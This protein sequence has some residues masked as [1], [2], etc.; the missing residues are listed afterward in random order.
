MSEKVISSKNKQDIQSNDN[1]E[2]EEEKINGELDEDI[3]NKDDN[4]NKLDEEDT[5][6]NI[7][8]LKEKIKKPTELDKGE[9][10]DEA[11]TNLDETFLEKS[12]LEN[13]EVQTKKVEEE[14][15]FVTMNNLQA[16]SNNNTPGAKIEENNEF[17]NSDNSFGVNKKD[18]NE[19][20]KNSEKSFNIAMETKD[21]DEA[22]KPD[23]NIRTDREA[24]VNNLTQNTVT[25]NQ[26][27]A[28]SFGPKPGRGDITVN[29]DETNDLGKQDLSLMVEDKPQSSSKVLGEENIDV[30]K[31]IINDAL[32]RNSSVSI[33]RSTT[34][35]YSNT[36]F[37]RNNRIKYDESE[38]EKNAK[39]DLKDSPE[40]CC[41]RIF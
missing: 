16:V 11:K 1:L 12:S 15:Q 36:A 27:A 35:R 18:I 31:S 33:R 22:L 2:F 10:S 14:P 4:E 8:S 3:K 7:S 19:D 37:I 28:I 26:S 25:D 40:K 21:N 29:R 13:E 6:N 17:E 32:N 34:E 9:N 20:T 5:D 41:C 23:F 30:E 39:I 38:L 24:S